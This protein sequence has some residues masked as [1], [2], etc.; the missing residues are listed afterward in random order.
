MFP[1]LG[2]EN[3][4]NNLDIIEWMW[5]NRL[6]L[7][8]APFFRVTHNIFGLNVVNLHN[9]PNRVSICMS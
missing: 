5:E 8:I 2:C 9:L 7:L 6:D 1:N 3:P 4:V